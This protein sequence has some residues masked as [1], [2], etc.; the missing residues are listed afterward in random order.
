MYDP[1]CV[2][3]C[4][5]VSVYI[6]VYSAKANTRNR[7]KITTKSRRGWRVEGVWEGRGEILWRVNLLCDIRAIY[8]ILVLPIAILSGGKGRKPHSPTV[9]Y[10]HNLEL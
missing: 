9:S 8:Y 2:C 3:V 4:M 10:H 1:I 7:T 6:Y 5:H